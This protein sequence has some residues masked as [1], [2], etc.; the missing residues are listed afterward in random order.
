MHATTSAAADDDALQIGHPALDPT[1]RDEGDG[2]GTV[3]AEG[4]RRLAGKAW[5]AVGRTLFLPVALW[6]TVAIRRN[7]TGDVEPWPP[8]AVLATW[9]LLLGG[10]LVRAGIVTAARRTLVARAQPPAAPPQAKTATRRANQHTER[11]GPGSSKTAGQPAVTLIPR[12]LIA[13]SG[14]GIKSASF[15][16]G[17]LNA[18][19]RRGI[20]QRADSVYAVSGG[21][22]A[23]SAF[24]LAASD[25]DNANPF[26]ATSTELRTLRNRTNYLIASG[27]VKFNLYAS[28]LFG[29]IHS[30]ALVACIGGLSLW[31]VAA[32]LRGLH[33]KPPESVDWRIPAGWDWYRL[34]AV[35][36][37]GLV[38]STLWPLLARSLN[39]KSSVPAAQEGVDNSTHP[40]AADRSAGTS[41]LK[42]LPIGIVAWS[43]VW[44]VCVPGLVLLTIAVH[45]LRLHWDA[46]TSI[47]SAKVT[48]ALGLSGLG[49]VLALAGSTWKGLWRPRAP[50]SVWGTVI[51]AFRKQVAPR[52]ALTILT[53]MGLFGA[54]S[55]LDH[56]FSAT[57]TDPSAHHW[58]GPA[59]F[60]VPGSSFALIFVLMWLGGNTSSMYPFYRERLQYAYL[61]TP[62]GVRDPRLSELDSGGPK[63]HLLATANIEDVDLA[64][65]GRHGLPFVFSR[66]AVGVTG[67]DTGNERFSPGHTLGP[68]TFAKFRANVIDRRDRPVTLSQAMAVS[69]AAVAPLAGREAG[70]RPYRLLFALLNVRLGV[71]LPSPWWA[72]A[73]ATEENCAL[74]RAQRWTAALERL[75]THPK[76]GHLLEEALGEVSIYD[77]WLYV[78]DGGHFDNLG[79]VEALR[80]VITRR[81]RSDATTPGGAATGTSAPPDVVIV[82]DG[83]GDQE[84]RFPT[85]GRAMATAR[86]DLN[87]DIRFDPQLMIRG[88]APLPEKVWTSADVFTGEDERVSAVCR[89]IYL[90]CIM[91]RDVPWDLQ[92][93]AATHEGFPAQSS[94]LEIYDEFDFEAYRRLGEAVVAAAASD[95]AL[96][97]VP[98]DLTRAG[99]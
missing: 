68:E 54:A 93:Y 25:S 52:L 38:L 42:D 17:A 14:G 57:I 79:L 67:F 16:I 84:D 77:P 64:P 7:T 4:R 85:M 51:T 53:F 6:A 74:T 87:L 19:H 13:C 39:Q 95:G 46:I 69:A 9:L 98:R 36:A 89:I 58:W 90:K 80:D 10:L 56:A 50:D 35:P 24:A 45:D 88:D 28:V 47:L 78:T 63:L 92:T 60:W 5:W 71:W 73:A 59:S 94:S 20:Y 32:S 2:V 82:L 81:H 29:M 70:M 62:T 33:L 34:W 86:M 61:D 96:D 3:V 48:A 1:A 72:T 26:G 44:I 65:T 8:T 41:G 27:R 76:G 37:L 91:P 21:G 75:V 66:D 23:A 55:V 49:A 11:R 83:S 18:L 15:C 99:G 97:R 40:A 31:F 22:Y 30:L 43:I 12:V